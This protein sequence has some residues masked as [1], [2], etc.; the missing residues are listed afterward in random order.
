MTSHLG[1]ASDWQ[2]SSFNLLSETCTSDEIHTLIEQSL[3]KAAIEISYL[4][5]HH[6]RNLFESRA[7]DLPLGRQLLTVACWIRS[8]FVSLDI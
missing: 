1:T 7:E 3:L 5:D 8:F 4:A 6:R 2:L